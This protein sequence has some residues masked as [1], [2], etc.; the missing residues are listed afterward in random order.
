[1]TVDAD[2]FRSDESSK[3]PFSSHAAALFA[4]RATSST[5]ITSQRRPDTV[6]I[7]HI[8]EVKLVQVE[9]KEPEAGQSRNWCC[10]LLPCMKPFELKLR[11]CKTG[12]EYQPRL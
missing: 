7:D 4:S 9:T 3:V 12:Y 6:G 5:E 11:R 8:N 2:V 1:M 10:S